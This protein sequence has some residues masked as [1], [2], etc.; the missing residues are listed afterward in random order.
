[1]IHIQA[2]VHQFLVENQVDTS[3]I[4]DDVC[5]VRF[6]FYRHTQNQKYSLLAQS[7]L[8][9]TASLSSNV[10]G[11]STTSSSSNSSQISS[12]SSES[13]RT[14]GSSSGASSNHRCTRINLFR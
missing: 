14:Q 9:R 10:N 12:S 7:F 11:G 8:R 6:F 1:M 3:I 2:E 4:P 13:L 5:P